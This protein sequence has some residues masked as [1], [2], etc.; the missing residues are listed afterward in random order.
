VFISLHIKFYVTNS[1]K[2]SILTGSNVVRIVAV[3]I[4]LVPDSSRWTAIFAACGKHRHGIPV[5]TLDVPGR[6][7]VWK[8]VAKPHYVVVGTW[9]GQTAAELSN[10]NQY[11]QTLIQLSARL[12]SLKHNIFHVLSTDMNNDITSEVQTVQCT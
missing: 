1:N 10:C 8:V 9:I 4:D 12:S 6:V 5:S 7:I 2:Q 3:D 11:T